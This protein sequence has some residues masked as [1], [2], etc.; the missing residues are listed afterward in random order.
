MGSIADAMH[1]ILVPLLTAL[2]LACSAGPAAA[3]EEPGRWVP[4]Y[5]SLPQGIDW[6]SI[7]EDGTAYLY[8]DGGGPDSGIFLFSS[9][10]HGQTWTPRQPPP[11]EFTGMVR[12]G[13]RL[14]GHGQ[15]NGDWFKTTDGGLTWAKLPG[16]ALDGALFRS[17]DF[18]DAGDDGRLVVTAGQLTEERDLC[19]PGGPERPLEE[20]P[21]YA[22]TSHDGG[23]TWRKALIDQPGGGVRDIDMLD[24]RHGALVAVTYDWTVTSDGCSGISDEHAVFTTHDG[25]AN[26][27]KAFDCPTMCISAGM[28]APNRIV[29]GSTQGRIYRTDDGGRTVTAS[30]VEGLAAPPSQVADNFN[31]WAVRFADCQYGYLN[32]NGLGTYRTKDGGRSWTREESPRDAVYIAVPALAVADPSHA[33]SGGQVVSRRIPGAD[34]VE[35]ASTEEDCA[36][37]SAQPASPPGSAPGRPPAQAGS[38]MRA[39]ALRLS[40]APRRVRASRKPLRLRVTVRAASEPVRGVSLSA[41]GLRRPVTTD[42]KGRAVLRLRIGKGRF[43]RITARAPDGRMAVRMLR[44]RR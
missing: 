23:A 42:R 41:P 44:V 11:F 1:R 9:A 20:Q 31:V 29:A 25:G 28:A 18:M 30:N 17:F 34:A 3:Q 37:L 33:L 36:A 35:F 16:P 19:K 6:L 22:W 14:I 27:R 43:L 12:F 10:D 8:H 2:V 26:W 24:A 21:V 7:F 32:T 38:E 4:S 39:P 40:I 13:G 5:S 15:A